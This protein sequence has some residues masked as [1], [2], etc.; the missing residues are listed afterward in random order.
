LHARQRKAQPQALRFGVPADEETWRLLAQ[1]LADVTA[2][3]E[4]FKR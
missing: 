1:R 2:T 4:L 3:V